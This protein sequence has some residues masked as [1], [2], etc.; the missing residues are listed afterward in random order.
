MERADC[1]PSSAR[2]EKKDGGDVVD[3]TRSDLLCGGEGDLCWKGAAA[4]RRWEEVD[5][6]LSLAAA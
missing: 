4:A 3:T 5:S 2:S 1:D 6:P